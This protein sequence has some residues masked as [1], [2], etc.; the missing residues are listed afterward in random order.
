MKTL[1]RLA[2]INLVLFCCGRPLMRGQN[3]VQTAA[4]SNFWY[5]VACS[6]DGRKLAAVNNNSGGAPIWTSTNSGASW[7]ALGTLTVQLN[8][9]SSSADGT[10]LTV[11][12]P[13]QAVYTST[14]SGGSWTSTL[15][16][17]EAQPWSS[18]A[19]SADGTNIF[20]TS[21][22]ASNPPAIYVSTNSG[23]V[24]TTASAPN[25]FWHSVAC[26]ADGTKALAGDSGY[27][28]GGSVYVSTNSGAKWT[29]ANLP[30]NHWNCVACSAD[31]NKM[32][33]AAFGGLIYV[34][35]NAGAAWTPSFSP[36]NYW[37]GLACSADG[38]R[39]AAAG[40]G[41]LMTSGDSGLT[42][43]SNNVRALLW[44]S[45][46]TSADGHLLAATAYG[47][48]VYTLQTT[49]SPLLNISASSAGVLL[50]WIVPSQSFVLQQNAD[51][52]TTNWTDV[53]T[54]PVLNLNT[55]GNEV[56]VTPSNSR[57]FYRLI[58]Q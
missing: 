47:A 36:N 48:G 27:L 31:G 40:P 34:S 37:S 12:S 23:S 11:L 19:T 7:T 13:S 3:W 33:A 21:V 4:P 35:T 55:L 46:T 10:T 57:M 17:N 1:V 30:D 16:G 24:W 29:A 26:S 9:V 20:L 28:I 8:F 22:G 44:N 41:F 43:E 5:S 45:V 56:T 38:T 42:W 52:G 18:V 58:A 39:L 51:L 53:A 49:P 54:T 25:D 50:S 2:L 15:P 32:A 14:N 6:A